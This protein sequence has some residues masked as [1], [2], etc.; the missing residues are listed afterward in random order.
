MKNMI[1]CVPYANCKQLWKKW[2][3]KYKTPFPLDPQHLI[4]KITKNIQQTQ[5]NKENIDPPC[6][7]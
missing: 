1:P 2:T 3:N 4:Q 5:V 6:K 7:P